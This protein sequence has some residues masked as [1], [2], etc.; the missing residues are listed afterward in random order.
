MYFSQSPER[1][2][3]AITM[4]PASIESTLLLLYLFNPSIWRFIKIKCNRI[5]YTFLDFLHIVVVTLGF[6]NLRKIL[7]WIK[8]FSSFCR[9][10]SSNQEFLFKLIISSHKILNLVATLLEILQKY[11]TGYVFVKTSSQT[12]PRKLKQNFNIFVPK[13]QA[14]SQNQMAVKA[15]IFYK[16]HFLEKAWPHNLNLLRMSSTAVIL[17]NLLFDYIEFIEASAF[18]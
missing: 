6:V 1:S 2:K 14:K 11:S 15:R 8:Y 16:K 7:M 9:K 13:I 18:E 3:S 5:K 17:R 4:R 12:F 10:Y